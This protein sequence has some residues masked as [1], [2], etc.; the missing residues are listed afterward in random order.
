MKKIIH[1]IIIFVSIFVLSNSINAW[2][3]YEIGNK[4]TYNENDYYV[5]KNS[6]E[7]NDT[8]T[9]LKAEPLSVEEVNTYGGVGTANN[10]VNMYNASSSASYY[11]TAYNWNGYGGM[12]Y[13]SSETCGNGTYTGCTTDYE[14]SEVKYVVDAWAATQAPSATEA[15]LITIDDLKDNLGYVLDTSATSEV[16]IPSSS[17]PTWV[18]NSNYWYWTMS[19]YND[20]A[21]N[22]WG[23]NIDGSLCINIVYNYNEVVRPVIVLPKTE[24]GDTNEEEIDNDNTS[25]DSDNDSN[26]DSD[27][28]SKVSVN[29]PNTLQK[30]SI[31]LIM[32]GVILISVSVI[33]VVRNRN[34]FNKKNG[35]K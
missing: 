2:S 32:I 5:I 34:I 22:V 20:S 17:T 21:S 26:N 30:I 4:V 1:F 3:K 19:Q 23:V 13:Y 35:E 33:I 24:L 31:I 14:E 15:R 18:Y 28:D 8:V 10:H 11:Q 7:N 29:V 9:M 27:N 6:D 16:Y 12:A 25:N